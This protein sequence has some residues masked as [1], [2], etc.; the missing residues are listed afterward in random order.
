M[1]ELIW[2]STWAGKDFAREQTAGKGGQQ[3]S[4]GGATGIRLCDPGLAPEL[5]LLELRGG[6]SQLS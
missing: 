3:A 1:P 6:K 4:G 5:W 2:G